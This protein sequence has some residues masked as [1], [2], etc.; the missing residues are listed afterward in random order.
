MNRIA[1]ISGSS[2]L[3]GTQLL[4]Q[5]FKQDQY[6]H[7]ISIG[8]RELALKHKKLLQVT[9]DFDHLDHVDLVGKLREKDLGGLNHPLIKSI[10]ENDFVMHAYCSLG[11]TIK[12]AGSKDKFYK[13]DHDFVIE[14]AKWVHRLGASKFLYVSALGADAN[15]SIF[16]NRVKGEVQED[17][18][19][20]PFD[21]LGIFQPSL[22]L[23]N[24]RDN[25]LGEEAGKVVMKVITALGIYRKYK[26]IYDHQVAKA[27]VS[28]AE[29]SNENAVEVIPSLKMHELNK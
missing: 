3:I 1:I 4:H 9:V 26:P 25:R 20:I 29:K 5:L 18:K 15:S 23:G 19:K 12:E 2:G 24:R 13:I 27:M 8:R 28:Y 16:Y 6:D 11:T 22:L 10:L 14:F 21:F 7:V 17:L